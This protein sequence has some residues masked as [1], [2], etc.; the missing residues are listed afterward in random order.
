MMA[1]LRRPDEIIVRE[2]KRVRHLPEIARHLVSQIDRF[3]AR[4][5]CSLIHLQAMLIGSGNEPHIATHQPLEARHD[6]GRDTF[7]GMTDMRPPVGVVDGGSDI[8]WFRHWRA[9]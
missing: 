7:I 9:P 4:L 1:R 8:E 5:A 3:T 2:I 6:I